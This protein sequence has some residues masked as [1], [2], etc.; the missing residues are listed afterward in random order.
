MT[1]GAKWGKIAGNGRI[2]G[3]AAGSGAA[4][5]RMERGKGFA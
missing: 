2:N 5:Q 4:N 3:I 1:P